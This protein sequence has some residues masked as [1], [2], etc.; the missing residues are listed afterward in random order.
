M[1]NYLTRE[2]AASLVGEE[3]VKSVD[4]EDC[5]FTGRVT[6]DPGTHEMRAGVRFLDESGEW[7]IKKIWV[8]SDEE[9]DEAGELDQ[10]DYDAGLI[11]YLV[12]KI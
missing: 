8:F 10:L 11:G 7:I 6:E 3:T 1:K 5:D 4:A 9:L 2:Q 12:E